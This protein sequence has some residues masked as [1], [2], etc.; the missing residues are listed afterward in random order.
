[1][2]RYITQL[3]HCYLFILGKKKVPKACY[4]CA[5]LLGDKVKKSFLTLLIYII[6]REWKY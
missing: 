5:A 1:M 4:M 2:K 3:K 6:G